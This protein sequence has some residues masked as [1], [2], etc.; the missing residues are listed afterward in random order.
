MTAFILHRAKLVWAGRCYHVMI[1]ARCLIRTFF[2]NFKSC[3]PLSISLRYPQHFKP[4]TSRRGSLYLLVVQLHNPTVYPALYSRFNPVEI[5][6]LIVGLYS[7]RMLICCRGLLPRWRVCPPLG[8]GC[9]PAAEASERGRRR[10]AAA[11]A[12]QPPVPFTA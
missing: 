9:V 3:F 4:T 1:L 7:C 6:L 8:V 12:T 2:F 10:S 11:L 5:F